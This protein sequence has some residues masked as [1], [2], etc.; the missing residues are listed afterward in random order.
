MA[1]VYLTSFGNNLGR[2]DRY[3]ALLSVD[4][5]PNPVR[6]APDTWS[7]ESQADEKMLEQLAALAETQ[8][9]V[10]AII[11]LV[12]ALLKIQ[13]TLHLAIGCKSGRHRSTIVCE[14]VKRALHGQ[15]VIARVTHRDS[16]PRFA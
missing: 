13:P 5:L 1:K 11:H 8:E 15:S 3:H 12:A 6:I 2:P 7:F 9:V 14:L 10:K 16:Q 4:E